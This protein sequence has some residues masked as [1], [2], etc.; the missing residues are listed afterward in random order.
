VE[1]CNQIWNPEYNHKLHEKFLPWQLSR[2]AASVD[3][4]LREYFEIHS[5]VRLGCIL[6]P[7]LLGIVMDWILKTSMKDR[8]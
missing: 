3:R 7:L 5:G 6:S 4:V 1:H 8:V 2:W